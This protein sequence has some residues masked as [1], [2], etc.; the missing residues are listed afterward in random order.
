MTRQEMEQGLLVHSNAHSEDGERKSAALT[1][2]ATPLNIV[3]LCG[4]IVEM[5][6]DCPQFVHFTVKE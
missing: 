6:G 3:R 1:R 2:T 4:P 5:I